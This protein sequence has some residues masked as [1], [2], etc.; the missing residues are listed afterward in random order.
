MG[1]GGWGWGVGGGGW[2]VGVGVGGG[3]WGV[4]SLQNVRRSHSADVLPG[5]QAFRAIGRRQS[6]T[7]RLLCAGLRRLEGASERRRNAVPAAV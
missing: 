2:G 7:L 3:G 6:G 4:A 5:S 1:G